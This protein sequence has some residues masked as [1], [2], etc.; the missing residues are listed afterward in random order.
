MNYKTYNFVSTYPLNYR[1]IMKN[2]HLILLVVLFC[3]TQNYLFAQD[4]VNIKFGKITPADFDL[5]K[6][7]FDTGAS[8][9]VIADIGSSGFDGNNDGWFSLNY[10]RHTRIK[11]INKNGMDAANVRIPLYF[12]GQAEEKLQN[13]KAITYTLEGGK[14]T[15]TELD[16][17]SIFKDKY[18]KN[19]MLVKFTLPGIKEGCIIEYSYTVISDFLRNLQ[20]WEFQGDYPILWSQ[21]DV[22]ISEFFNYVFLSQGHFQLEHSVETKRESYN[23]SESEGA[24]STQHYNISANVASHKWIA[25]NVPALKEES[26]T[27][28]ISNHVA[29]VEFQLSQ[30][31]FPNSPVKDIMGNWASLSTDLLKD[32][33]F[34]ASLAKNNN[35]LDDELKP[36]TQGTTDNLEK[37]K[38]VY[39]YVRDRFTCTGKRGIWLSA[40]LKTIDKNKNG[41]VADI[42]LLLVTML[43]HEAIDAYPVLLSTRAHGYTHEF[44]PL[45]GR[46]NYVVCAVNIADKIYYLDASN[47]S[48]GFNRLPSEC[49]NGH[50]R[51]ILPD[52]AK[53][54][55]FNSDSLNEKKLVTVFIRSDKPGEWSGHF[56]ANMG[57]YESL[58]VRGSIKDKGEDAF[59]KNIQLA[60][61]GE[62]ELKDKKIDKIKELD[63]PVKIDYDFTMKQD[64]D[65]IYFSP[66]MTEGYKE[67]YF[68]A[69]ERSY[70][71]EMP[72]VFDET[73]IFNLD[74]PADYTV[75]DLPKSTKV[76]FGEND[77]FF[78][79]L[80]DKTPETIRLRS[81]LKINRS[82]YEPDEY[83]DLREFFSYVVKK[84]AEQIVLKKKK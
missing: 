7:K 81:R 25:K 12:S 79:Y 22:R 76:N 33:D 84:H 34:G 75:E 82:F 64:E 2:K 20:P 27:S 72:Y 10:K 6:N 13:V 24:R 61:T 66:M 71:V 46:F 26:F 47:T 77:G 19:R 23:I 17:K 42:N 52:L 53:A 15:E 16:K 38:K 21:Y 74:I 29:K 18:D 56:A 80:V 8:A 35:W 3:C 67:N 55:Y 5:S 36:V 50:G 65:I 39:A 60:Y 4:K 41:Y 45:L 62:I 48:L 9:V 32:E 40:P 59:F 51:V 73:Y 78:E 43:R 54:V 58:G 37:T 1:L 68:K 70:P 30:Y 63:Q 49:Y 14:I 69:A 31:R 28:A 11:I 83:N 57:Y 44:Y